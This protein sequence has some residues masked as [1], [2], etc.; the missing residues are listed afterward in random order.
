MTIGYYVTRPLVVEAIEITP[1]WFEE[2]P[3]ADHV[4]SNARQR[5][6]TDPVA[7]TVTIEH[8][9]GEREVARITDWLVR[10]VPTL[11]GLPRWSVLWA[12]DFH[13]RF[14]PHEVPACPPPA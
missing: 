10:A 9:T 5:I 2:H 11:H 14:I 12:A 8:A 13:D 1:A 4:R 7:R 3:N 6:I